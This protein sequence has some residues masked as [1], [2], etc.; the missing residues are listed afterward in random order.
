MADTTQGTNVSRSK[1]ARPVK[2]QGTPLRDKVAK[3]FSSAPQRAGR[4]HRGKEVD[5]L[6]RADSREDEVTRVPARKNPIRRKV[7]AFCRKGEQGSDAPRRPS[8]AE[9]IPELPPP[10]VSAE[11]DD[12]PET[13]EACLLDIR[14]AC[15]SSTAD[16]RLWWFMALTAAILS[17]VIGLEIHRQCVHLQSITHTWGT[18]EPPV[19]AHGNHWLDD[20]DEDDPQKHWIDSYFKS[21]M[22][23]ANLAASEILR[24]WRWMDDIRVAPLV[25]FVLMPCLLWAWHVLSMPPTDPVSRLKRIAMSYRVYPDLLAYLTVKYPY[26]S[27][28]PAAKPEV[29]RHVRDWA[30]SREKRWPD[31]VVFDQTER[32]ML[33]I[34]AFCLDS[35]TSLKAVGAAYLTTKEWAAPYKP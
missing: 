2:P 11:K 13:A 19:D 7:E 25:A 27:P 30:K 16:N 9:E 1:P 21:A 35:R 15:G 24:R 10:P 14:Q 22:H 17:A 32:S 26:V 31:T 29:G 3:S 28:D 23:F 4:S 6:A 33:A 12:P 18:Q 8:L 20:D 5:S 34:A